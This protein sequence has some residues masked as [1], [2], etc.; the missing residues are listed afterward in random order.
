ML[1][2]QCP[3]CANQ[4]FEI[5]TAKPHELKY[6]ILVVQCAGCKQVIGTLGNDETEKIVQLLSNKKKSG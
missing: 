4:S 6:N 2:N 1:N 3:A 5:I